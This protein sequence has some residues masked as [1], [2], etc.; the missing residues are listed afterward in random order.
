MQQTN[1]YM[2]RILLLLSCC[3]FIFCAKKEHEIIGLWDVKSNYYRA[4]YKIEFQN[5]RL[6][7]KVIYYN[8]DTTVLK[9]TKTDKDLFLFNLK[10]KSDNNYI[11]AVSGAT[12]TNNQ[13]TSITIKHKDTL[14]VTSYIM[15]KPLT[16]IWIRNFN[17]DTHE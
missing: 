6:V 14:E 15:K 9:E 16:E 1:N 17:N 8:D 10:Q 4:T 13:T 12:K 3:L 11:D 2:K 5:N 7:G